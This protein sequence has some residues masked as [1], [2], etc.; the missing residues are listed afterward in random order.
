MIMLPLIP[1]LLLLSDVAELQSSSFEHVQNPHAHHELCYQ[2]HTLSV[3]VNVA[4]T[5]LTFTQSWGGG[6][7]LL[8]LALA[9]GLGTCFS[10]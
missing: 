10:C 1:Q 2:S 6:L 7:H 5:T 8:L 4:A 3:S 9:T